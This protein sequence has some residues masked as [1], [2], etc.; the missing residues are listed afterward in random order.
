M[1]KR[2]IIIFSILILISGCLGSKSKNIKKRSANIDTA[3]T[4]AE[5]NFPDSQ[6]LTAKATGASEAEA[7][8]NA[9]AE[10]SSIFE[11]KISSDL[12]S[13]TTQI[14]GTKKKGAFSKTVK[15]NI[16]IK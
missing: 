13:S 7:K 16:R 8:K 5:I 6:Y 11:A 1:L 2:F 4:N 15:N 14:T 3:Q 10:I 12:T 9:K